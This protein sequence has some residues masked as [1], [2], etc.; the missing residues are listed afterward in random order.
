MLF[1]ATKS[2]K[3]QDLTMT[4]MK[5]SV[6]FINTNEDNPTATVEGLKHG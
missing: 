6:D 3:T 4:A 1:S 2:E 5:D